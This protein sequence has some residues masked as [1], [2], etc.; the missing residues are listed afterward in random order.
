M[1]IEKR[2]F[3]PELYER[4]KMSRDAAITEKDE[5]I[6]DFRLMRQAASEKSFSGRLRRAVQKAPLI[7][8]ELCQR[9]GI[10][11]PTIGS[12][13]RG[14]AGLDSAAYIAWLRGTLKAAGDGTLQPVVETGHRRLSISA[15]LTRAV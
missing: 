5:V 9:A 10:D 6:A 12:F 4:W 11:V 13:L 3:T 8:P 15:P 1:P 7:L 2:R 14:E